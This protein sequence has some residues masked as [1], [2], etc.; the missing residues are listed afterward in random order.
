MGILLIIC[1][2]ACSDGTNS[3]TLSRDTA[4]RLLSSDSLFEGWEHAFLPKKL[5]LPCGALS[6]TGEIGVYRVLEKQGLVRV[7]DA[8]NFLRPFCLINGNPSILALPEWGRR[9]A[10][11]DLARGEKFDTTLRFYNLHFRVLRASLASVDGISQPDESAEATADI[12]ARVSRTPYSGV[13]PFPP[14]TGQRRSRVLFRRYDDG[15]RFVKFL[16]N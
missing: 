4:R 11:L 1:P 12:T 2:L 9:T 15:W 10:K 13:L 16:P 6:H 8:G 5:S 7:E 3:K 14:D